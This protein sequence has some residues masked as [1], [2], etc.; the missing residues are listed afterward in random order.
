MLYDKT[1]CCYAVVPFPSV[2]LLLDDVLHTELNFR[3]NREIV[4]EMT[5]FTLCPQD[6]SCFVFPFCSS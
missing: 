2:L 5:L 1:S 3:D 4:N 6:M